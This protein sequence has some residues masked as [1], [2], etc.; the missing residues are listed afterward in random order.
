MGHPEL[1]KLYHG[2]SKIVYTRIS[3]NE[4]SMYLSVKQTMS[5][6]LRRLTGTLAIPVPRKF[7]NIYIYI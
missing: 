2:I 4:L 6:W 1:G 7:A 5:T 3:P